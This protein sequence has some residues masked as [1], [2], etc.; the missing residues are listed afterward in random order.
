MGIFGDSREVLEIFR[1]REL[2]FGE[3]GRRVRGG[4]GLILEGVS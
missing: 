4:M 3:F 1:G 2:S